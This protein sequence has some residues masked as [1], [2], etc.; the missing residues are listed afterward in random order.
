M[1]GLAGVLL[2]AGLLA[3]AWFFPDLIR[4]LAYAA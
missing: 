3:W 1:R 4:L 2:I